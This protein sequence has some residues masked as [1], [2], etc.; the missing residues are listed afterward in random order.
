MDLILQGIPKVQCYID[1]ILITGTNDAE[2]LKTLR[3]VLECLEEHW[4]RVKRDKCKFMQ[5][6]VDFLGYRIDSLGLHTIPS[7]LDAIIQAPH[8]KDV[9]QLRSFLGLINY[10]GKFIPNLTS[11]I[12]PLH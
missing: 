6:F 10:Y 8:P 2:H 1:D 3:E 7:K 4:L 12:H 11:L 9:Q 5:E